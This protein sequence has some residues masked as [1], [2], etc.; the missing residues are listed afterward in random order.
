MTHGLTEEA[1]E[2]K[3]SLGQED[4][5]IAT[6]PRA[7]LLRPPPP[8]L[9]S[10]QNWPLLTTTR[11]FFEQSATARA[12]GGPKLVADFDA[13]TKVEGQWE[14]DEEVILDE[15]GLPAAVGDEGED[16]DGGGW[17][18]GDDDLELPDLEVGPSSAAEGYFVPPTKGTSQS[19]VW[20]NNSQLPADH[21]TAGSLETAMRLLHDQ[22]GI[23]NFDP[24]KPLFV[25]AYSTARTCCIALA[26][27]PPLFTYPHRNWQ[28][29]GAKKGVAA[30]GLRLGTLVHRLQAA[31]Q[32]TT[33]GKFS[34]AVSKFR[35]I[36]H[37]V[38]FIVVENRQELTEAQQL[39]GICREY[40][41][42]L[43]MEISRKEL[44]KASL[45][46]QQRSCEMAAYFTHCNLQPV[47]LMLSL[48]TA[49]NLFY[50]V[51][52]RRPCTLILIVNQHW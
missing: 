25:Q 10:D 50:K 29:A 46:D 36:L 49:Q 12:S 15:E 33:Q 9:Q 4:L 3:Q 45:E 7:K 23:V 6:H 41:L 31:Y 17:D 13:V 8:I 51:K 28:D 52:H 16:E 48:R 39:I 38:P 37:S 18:A 5:T 19:Q 42:G 22:I 30:V 11:S 2:I 34:D 32:L 1:E 20:C 44:P 21:A 40:I 27:L 35:H 26:S 24:L 43:S 47:H 14:D